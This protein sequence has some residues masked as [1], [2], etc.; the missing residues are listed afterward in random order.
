MTWSTKEMENMRVQETWEQN[1]K[2]VGDF[3]SLTGILKGG[4]IFK[5]IM[6]K[7]FS[8]VPTVM[9]PK[10]KKMLIN[11]GFVES[12]MYVKILKPLKEQK[13]NRITFKEVEN[14]DYIKIL[15]RIKAIGCLK[16]NLTRF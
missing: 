1:K 2:A 7:K 9:N 4:I 10:V 13:Q 16:I 12:G 3:F 14:N 6:D 5:V 15:F 8:E 11:F